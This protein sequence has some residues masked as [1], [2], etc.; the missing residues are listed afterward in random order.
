MSENLAEVSLWLDDFNDI[1][2]DFDSRHF[3]KR[4]I[5]DDSEGP[6]RMIFISMP[7]LTARLK[8]FL[9]TLPDKK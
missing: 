2:S 9:N 5:S 1:Y 3:L 6:A 8:R 7:L 4:R